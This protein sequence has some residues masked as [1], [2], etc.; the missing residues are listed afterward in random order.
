MVFGEQSTPMGWAC[1][2]DGT[3]TASDAVGVWLGGTETPTWG[4]SGH[5]CQ[6]DEGAPQSPENADSREGV[7]ATNPRCTGMDQ[8]DVDEDARGRGAAEK[9]DSQRKA[10]YKLRQEY[11]T[12]Q[13]N[14]TRYNDE[15][16]QLCH[17]TSDSDDEE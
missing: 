11:V 5:V 9:M 12:R 10:D 2:A 14:N 4:A 6:N 3:G 17:M 15:M 16:C 8:A 1:C 13:K 7:A